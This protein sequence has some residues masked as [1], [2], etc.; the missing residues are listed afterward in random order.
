LRID[1]YETFA[2]LVQTLVRSDLGEMAQAEA[3]LQAA[4]KIKSDHTA[5]LGCA[6]WVYLKK[7]DL[8]KAIQY[9]SE[10]IRAN[11]HNG[12]AYYSR[13]TALAAKGETL[14]VV[15]DY[16][17]ALQYWKDIHVKRTAHC[18]VEMQAFLAQ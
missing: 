9:A 1:A 11:P 6:A 18:E 16:R 8:D 4:L 3:D 15:L 17:K 5:V 13:G 14:A 2:Y 12:A 7:G 10:A